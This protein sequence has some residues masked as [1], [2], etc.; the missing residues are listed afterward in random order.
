MLL[1]FPHVDRMEPDAQIK[2]IPRI[3]PNTHDPADGPKST[4]ASGQTLSG[5]VLIMDPEFLG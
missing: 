5:K 3:K 1:L 2:F 4:W